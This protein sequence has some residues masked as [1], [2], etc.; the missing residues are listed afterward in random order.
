[1][2][3]KDETC[4]NLLLAAPSGHRQIHLLKSVTYETV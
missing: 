1:M 2:K 4:N 3:I